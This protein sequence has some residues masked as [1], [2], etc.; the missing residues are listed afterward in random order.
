MRVLVK[1]QTAAAQNGIYTLTTA[2]STTVAWVLTRATDADTSAK[3][4]GAVI[5]VDQGTVNGSMLLTNDWKKTS[6]VGTTAMNWRVVIDNGNVGSYHHNSGVTAGTY[7]SVTVNAQG[8]VTGGSNPTTLSGYGITDAAPSSHVSSGGEAHATAT[9]AAH[10]FMSSTD[11]AKLDSIASNANNYAH[12]T[13]DGNLHVPATGTG[14]NGKVLMAGATAGS[15]SWQSINADVVG[16]V[17][18]AGGAMSGALTVNNE[19]RTTS[20]NSMRMVYGNYGTFWR[21]DGANMYL[22]FTNAGDQYGGYNSLRPMYANLANGN[23]NFGHSVDVNGNLSVNTGSTSWIDM[24]SSAALQ[25]RSAVVTASASAIVRQEHADRHFILG[26]LG[27]SCFG[28]FMINKSR[29]A[30]GTDA[31]AYLSADGTW[32]C[33][34]NVSA[35]DYQVRSDRRLKSEFTEIKDAWDLW[36]T[37][38]ISE[39][40]KEGARE[41]GFIAQDF[42]KDHKPAI[43]KTMTDDYLNLKPMSV[44]AI[45]GKVIQ[46]L[47]DRVENLESLLKECMKRMEVGD[48]STS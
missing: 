22:M 40:T 42:E 27:N 45:A 16:A 10:G 43:A 11:K 6:T 4:A 44:L 34:G 12:P 30:N 9:T 14:N 2:G 15:L 29:T 28:V 31:G 41:Y 48:A 21:Q 46:S 33:G 47:Q 36:K 39:Y 18:V 35:N 8:H 13:G 3:L 17:P 5:T 23:V 25:S 20:A 24:R 32:Y 7:R 37:L 19:I 38:Q 1:N 26:G